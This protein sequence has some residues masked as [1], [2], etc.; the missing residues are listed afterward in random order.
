V[1][2]EDELWSV[3]AGARV[4][5]LAVGDVTGDEKPEILAGTDSQQLQCYDTTGELI[6]KQEFPFFWNR[7]GNVVW[8]DIGDVDADG[9]NEI[10]MAGE[11][12]HYYL[13]DGEG[14]KLWEFYVPHSPV[15]GALGDVTGD[16]KLEIVATDEYYSGRVIAA[17]GK[18]LFRI[19]ITQPYMSAA[20]APDLDGD[21]KCEAVIGGQDMQAHVCA[22]DGAL[23]FDANVGNVV[24]DLAAVPAG[25]GSDLIVA[26]DGLARNLSC[27][28]ATGQEQW[29]LTLPGTPRRLAVCGDTIAAGCNDGALRLFGP[30]GGTRGVIRLGAPVDVLTSV[31]AGDGRQLAVCASGNL[32]TAV[33]T[34]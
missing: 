30:D 31:K 20:L 15:E 33:A 4:H 21:G 8:V 16:G 13:L 24:T 25:A 23:L 32:L 1:T 26:S 7:D 10:A 22:G 18:S 12:W 6:W 3:E 28:G 17:D 2:G 27:Y 19:R 14:K 34:D 9:D 5:C 29:R 11:N